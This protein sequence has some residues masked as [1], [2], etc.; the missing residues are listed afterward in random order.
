V[1]EASNLGPYFGFTFDDPQAG[2]TE[3]A[4]P[5][6]AVLLFNSTGAGVAHA[7]GVWA[8]TAE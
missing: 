6:G 2:K 4:G 5:G 7:A 1:R 8:V 3:A